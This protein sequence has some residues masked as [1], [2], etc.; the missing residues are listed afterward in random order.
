MRRLGAAVGFALI[1]SG[2]VVT[3]ETQP[4]VSAVT[5][6]VAADDPNCREY[7]AQAMV[8]GQAQDIVG[9][10]CLRPDGSWIVTEGPAGAPPQ[11]MI[12][13]PPPPPPYAY[14]PWL[15]DFPVGFSLGTTVVFVDRQHHLHHMQIA[16]LRRFRLAAG[17]GIRPP[18]PVRPAYGG[19]HR[20]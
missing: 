7:R 6:D 11:M 9:R 19:M 18:M 1:C 20:G 15:W 12:Y 8:N 16:G 10:A 4:V 14:D 17:G 2:C 13:P 5:G 3:P